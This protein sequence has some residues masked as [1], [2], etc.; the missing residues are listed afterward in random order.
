M[1]ST[2]DYVQYCGEFSIPM[3]LNTVDDG[4]YFGGFPIL[5]MMF[6]TEEDVLYCGG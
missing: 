2:N 6:S 3:M 1:F 5:W 4:Q